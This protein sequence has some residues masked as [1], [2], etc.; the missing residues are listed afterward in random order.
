MTIPGPRE[1]S[2]RQ[3]PFSLRQLTLCFGLIAA[4]ICGAGLTVRAVTAAAA[5]H[6]GRALA[7]GAALFMAAAVL[8]RRHRLRQAAGV[9]E[10]AGVP[11]SGPTVAE[12]SLMPAYES[13]S[14][15]EFEAAVAEL[16]KRDGCSDVQVTGGAGDL[17]ADV[18]ATA[19][20]GRRVVMQCKRYSPGHKVGSQELQRFGGTC[21]AVHGAHTATVVTTSEFTQPGAEY[22]AQ[23]G[24]GCFGADELAAWAAGT[25]PSPWDA[26][27]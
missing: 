21:F 2:G 22:A 24:I 14:P 15:D 9:R 1:R 25:G 4:L 6:P 26:E 13:M 20:D 8:R 10:Y 11:V 19:P 18:V 16:C 3:S 23:C 7:M 27:R 12:P 17:G 5:D